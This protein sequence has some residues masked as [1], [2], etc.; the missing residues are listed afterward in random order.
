MK[1]ELTKEEAAQV[2]ALME[3]MRGLPAGT[4]RD[5]DGYEAAGWP[6]ATEHRKPGLLEARKAA[7]ERIVVI[8]NL[9]AKFQTED[10]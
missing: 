4:V 6:G 9:I 1:I 7:Q 2:V 5:V 10:S 8:D 3:G